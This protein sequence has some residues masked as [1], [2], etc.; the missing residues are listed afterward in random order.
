MSMDVKATVHSNV[1]KIALPLLK[2]GQSGATCLT[3]SGKRCKYPN[4]LFSMLAKLSELKLPIYPGKNQYI[5]S[6]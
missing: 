4:Q 2:Q 3:A 1:V 5:L 6:G